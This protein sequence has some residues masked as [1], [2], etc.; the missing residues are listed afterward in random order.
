MNHSTHLSRRRFRLQGLLIGGGLTLLVLLG[1]GLLMRSDSP[2]PGS[3]PLFQAHRAWAST[4]AGVPFSVA[5]VAERA[6]PSVVNIA[7]TRVTKPEANPFMRDPMFRE[8]F[9]HFGGPMEPSP[10]KQQGLGSGVIL[11]G[12]GLVVTNNHVVANADDIRVLL[13]DNREFEAKVV[14]TDPKSDLAVLKL[15]GASGLRPITIGDSDTMRLG[16]VVLAI[17]NPFGVGQTVTMG[18]VSAKGRANMGIVDYE[19][20]IQT[21]A[22]INPGNS[23]GALV[24]M[25]GELVGINTAILSR[26]GGYQGIGF[27]IPT[28]MVKPITDALVKGG[29]VVRGWLGIVIQEVSSDMAKAMRLPTDKG[30]LISDVEPNGPAQKAGL[31]RGDLVVKIE[32]KA[33]DS[34]SRLRN[35]VA[36]LGANRSI[37]L[38]YYRDGK[39]QSV[40]LSLGEQPSEPGAFGSRG[41]EHGAAVE[42]LTVLPLDPGSR[43]RFNI[44]PRVPYGVV[45]DRVDPEGPAGSSGLQQ[46]DVLL[47]LNRT[48]LESVEQFR[49]MWTSVKGQV[50]LLVYRQGTTVYLL[51]TK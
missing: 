24:N 19:D 1:S 43:R 12:D 35:L 41:D 20:F 23:G 48:K 17:G 15:K 14:G 18:I 36:A 9:R 31:K 34:T 7:S 22:A 33:V 6:L 40:R 28:N 13:S 25:K 42:G 16:D 39:L 44:S 2:G 37:T 46:G 26:S 10:R 27:A 30:A 3:P 29:K 8:F 45:V 11:S 38:E 5:D 21:D 51:I 47:E 50:L 32:G 4:P 49:R